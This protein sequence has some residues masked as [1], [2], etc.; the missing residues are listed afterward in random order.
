MRRLL[1]LGVLVFGVHAARAER[2]DN[3]PPKG[4]VALFNGKDFTGWKISDNGKFRVEDGKIVINGPRAHLFT[5]KEFKNF[6]FRAEVMTTP[7]SN[8]GTD[9]VR[10]NLCQR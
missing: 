3:T 10:E 2:Q 6:E 8:S 5:V 9:F 1:L 4:F 7:G